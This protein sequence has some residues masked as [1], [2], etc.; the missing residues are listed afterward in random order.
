M[1][2]LILH[3]FFFFYFRGIKFANQVYLRSFYTSTLFVIDH[4][5]LFRH[6]VSRYRVNAAIFVISHRKYRPLDG[7][8]F[9]ATQFVDWRI[10]RAL[11]FV[12]LLKINAVHER[13]LISG[14]SMRNMVFAIDRTCT[15]EKP[16][17][18]ECS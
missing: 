16:R 18:R 4:L 10:T 1:L 11:Q 15:P 6:F 12:I 8:C 14:A 17:N 3:K 9:I 2:W 7:R 5:T 13:M